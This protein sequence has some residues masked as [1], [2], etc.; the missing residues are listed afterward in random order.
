M[1]YFVKKINKT[2]VEW[3][4]QLTDQEYYITRKQGTERA[5]TGEY[6]SHYEKGKYHCV[7]CNELLFSSK[8]K[9]DSGTGW[10]SFFQPI[11]KEAVVEKEDNKFFMKRTEIVCA[12]C[13]AHLGHSFPDGPEPTGIRYCINSTALKFENEK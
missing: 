12:K 6:N 8:H 1:F 7:C 9:F 2:D 13:E 3:K 4:E 10:P 11:Q 5:F